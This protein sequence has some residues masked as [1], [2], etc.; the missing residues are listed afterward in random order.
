MSE[1]KVY[2][3]MFER[4]NKIGVVIKDGF[5][6][7]YMV[8]DIA[9]LYN[10]DVNL[11]W[12]QLMEPEK[13]CSMIGTLTC[14]ESKYM[15]TEVGLTRWIVT[16]VNKH[17][18]TERFKS[19][20]RETVSPAIRDLCISID[21]VEPEPETE[22]ESTVTSGVSTS[23]AFGL[24]QAIK[25]VS[26]LGLDSIRD[27][28][29]FT[30]ITHCVKETDIAGCVNIVEIANI[31]RVESNKPNNFYGDVYVLMSILLH[32]GYIEVDNETGDLKP[33]MDAMQY[34]LMIRVRDEKTKNTF[35]MITP[36]G[37][38]YFLDRYID[39]RLECGF[40]SM[41]NLE[42]MASVNELSPA[43]ERYKQDKYNRMYA[44]QIMLE[45]RRKIGAN[46]GK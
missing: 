15:M 19:W 41:I 4:K 23:S 3:F 37:L 21:Y 24:M 12:G 20:L 42:F 10:T 1:Y 30:N 14:S 13:Q 26:A 28:N 33:T 17:P 25:T 5:L 6:P 32:D 7:L 38:G 9:R 22:E 45:A 40:S 35:L 8:E 11:V 36:D 2:D 31:F 43:L 34:G 46:N 29:R 18:I 44:R 39:R 16:Y 27:R